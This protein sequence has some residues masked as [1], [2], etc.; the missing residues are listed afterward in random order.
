M[1]QEIRRRLAVYRSYAPPVEVAGRTVV[2]ID[3]GLAS[4]FTAAAVKSLRSRQAER[5]FVAAPVASRSAVDMLQGQTD[6]VIALHVCRLGSFAVAGFYKRWH[7]LTDDEVIEYLREW[8]ARMISVKG[9]QVGN[10]PG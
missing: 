5:I 6:E 4:G 10:I 8:L 9:G 3:A 2:I 1:S 7:D